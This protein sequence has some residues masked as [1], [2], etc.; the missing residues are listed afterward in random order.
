MNINYTTNLDQFSFHEQNRYVNRGAVRRLAES[1]KRVGLKVPITVSKKNVILDGQHRV[2][3]I[4]LI[5]KAA[6]NPVKLSYIQKNM[7][8]ADV[9]EMNAHQLAWR[10]SDWIHYYATGGNENYIR[11]REA[12]EKFRPHKMT[13]ICALLSENE[14]AHTKVVTSGKYVYEMTPE[15]ERILKKLIAYGKMNSSFT[16]KAV[17][18]AVVDMRKLDGFNLDRLFRAL[19]QNF[20]SILNQ[21]GKDNWARHFVR[22]YNKGL[23]A[24]RLNADD[25]PSSY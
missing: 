5:N 15:K 10:M 22:F 1:I 8:I 25:L 23:R 19:D 4:R 11:L 24:G 20:E 13:S 17:L 16:S 18:M 3:A 6:K 12:G 21:S 2:E 14:G 7:S 9:A